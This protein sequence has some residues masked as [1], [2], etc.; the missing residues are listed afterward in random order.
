MNFRPFILRG[1]VFRPRSLC[2][3]LRQALPPLCGPPRWY[4]I[5][6]LKFPDFQISLQSVVAVRRCLS[7][8]ISGIAVL[9]ANPYHLSAIR[10]SVRTSLQI[11]LSLIEWNFQ[12]VWRSFLRLVCSAM[13]MSRASIPLR[14]LQTKTGCS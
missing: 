14:I 9:S 3:L 4:G 7:F 1:G 11:R 12:M 5:R 13:K 10:E 8:V 6:L 2:L